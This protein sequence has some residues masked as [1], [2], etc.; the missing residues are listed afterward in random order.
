MRDYIS[1]GCVPHGENC[2]QLG[3]NYNPVKAK[4]ECKALIGQLRRIYG[5]EPFGAR[6][7][8]K[9]FSHDFGTYMEVVC[10]YDDEVEESM[11]YAFS[12]E[13]IP[14]FWDEEAKKELI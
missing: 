3:P 7:S 11:N 12:C 5:D 2:E 9:S 4:Q 13:D 8:V 6:L 14:E 10:Y 1:I